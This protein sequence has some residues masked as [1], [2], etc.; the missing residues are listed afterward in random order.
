[1]A[2]QALALTAKRIDGTN[3]LRGIR[4]ATIPAER[5]TRRLLA[6]HEVALQIGALSEPGPALELILGEACRL[7][8]AAGGSIH[9]WDEAEQLLRC[10]LAARGDSLASG[11]LEQPGERAAA[12]AFRD[13]RTV[14]FEQLADWSGASGAELAAGISSLVSVPL[15]LGERCLGTLTLY[16]DCPTRW[17][18][19]ED[20][21][22]LELLGDQAAT[23]LERARLAESAARAQAI[24]ELH[25][26]KADFVSGVSQELRTPLTYILGYAELLQRGPMEP[27]LS[28]TAYGE[29]HRAAV[30]MARLIDDLL[31]FSRLESQSLPSASSKIDLNRLLAETFEAARARA[32]ERQLGLE[33]QPLPTLPA[34]PVQIRQVVEKLI[35]N[36]LRYAPAGPI[37]L[38]SRRLDD[39]ARVEV[40][41]QGP[42]ISQ[43]ERERVFEPLHR[44]P[45]SSVQPLRGAGLGLSI[46]RQLVKSHGGEVGVESQPGRGSCFWFTL[47]LS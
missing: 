3:A 21:W 27:E 38:R 14:R 34:D 44:G 41:D 47:P 9:L 18:D 32:T 1:M 8:C 37:L 46:V 20:A 7:L 6:L 17:F 29:I 12:L 28:R 4:E 36:A 23:A 33:L 22:L 35:E 11:G 16:V 30:Q 10:R 40:V 19:E 39:R 42:G 43:A 45:N 2:G 31:D 13:G 24:A 5:R 15:R 25:D 26:L